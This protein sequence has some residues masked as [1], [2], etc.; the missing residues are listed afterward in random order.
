MDPAEWIKA[1]I[2]N[3]LTIVIWPVFIAAVIGAFVWA[4]IL[5]LTAKGEPSKLS[6]AKTAVI[7]AVVGIVVALLAFSAVNIVQQIIPSAPQGPGGAAPGSVPIGGAC[8]T[9]SECST[10][11]C[12][13]GF[14]AEP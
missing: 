3:L 2:N 7:W 6:Q 1:I 12:F 10:S 13:N 5:F 8:N 14:C 4:G 11:N 9:N